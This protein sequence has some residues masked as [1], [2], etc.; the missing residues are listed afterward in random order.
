MVVNYFMSSNYIIMQ[1]HQ[2]HEL[3]EHELGELYEQ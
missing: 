1:E 3:Y 2:E